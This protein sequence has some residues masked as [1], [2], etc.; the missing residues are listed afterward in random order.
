MLRFFSEERGI[1]VSCEGRVRTYVPQ[2][3]ANTSMFYQPVF[4]NQQVMGQLWHGNHLSMKI[5]L[6]S[7]AFQQSFLVFARKKSKQS[8][9]MP[10]DLVVQQKQPH[11]CV[12]FLGVFEWN[13]RKNGIFYLGIILGY[14]AGKY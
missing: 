4:S 7:N 5:C 12:L 11:Y 8:W 14:P 3:G 2:A 9:H 1:S 6:I 10:V 13:K